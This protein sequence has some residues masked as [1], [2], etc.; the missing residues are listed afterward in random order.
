MENLKYFPTT[1]R[2]NYL[3]S[4]N[5]YTDT[6]GLDDSKIKIAKRIL[7]CFEN[8]SASPETDYSSIYIYR[9]GNND[10]KQVTLARGFTQDGGNLWKVLESYINK[11]GTY[12]SFFSGYQNKMSNGSLWQDK[13]FI[14]TL[15]KASKE[16]QLMRDAQDEIFDKIY[17]SGALKYFKTKGFSLPLSFAV[18]FDSTLQSGSVLS[19]LIKRF[20]EK[21]PSNGGNEKKWVSQY[22]D[23]RHK[24][25]TKHSNEAVRNS[26]YR[27]KFFLGELDK[28]NWNM[29]CPLIANNSK[30]C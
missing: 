12:A 25:L 5:D 10:R 29:D 1:E 8:D 21:L 15:I 26:S 11:N 22:V 2:E 17:L 30:V 19:F 24:W 6:F 9:D 27:T 28:K 13:D 7:N 20:P 18:I 23:T 16:D 3:T 14:N 4:L